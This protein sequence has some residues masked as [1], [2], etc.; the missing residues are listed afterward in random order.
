VD[1]I[2]GLD[3]AIKESCSVRKN[4]KIQHKLSRIQTKM[5]TIFLGFLAQSKKIHQTRNWQENYNLLQEVKR[6][7]I[8]KDNASF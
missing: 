3:A 5:L 4:K 7:Q 8:Q 1:K 2:G 6:L